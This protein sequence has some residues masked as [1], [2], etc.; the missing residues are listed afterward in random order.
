MCGAEEETPSVDG[1]EAEVNTRRGP[2][3]CGAEGLGFKEK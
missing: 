1:G 2:T 3:E